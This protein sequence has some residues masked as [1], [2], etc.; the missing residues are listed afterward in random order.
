MKNFLSIAIFILSIIPFV[1][2]AQLAIKSHAEI[3][4]RSNTHMN[5]A[6]AVPQPLPSFDFLK[7][8]IEQALVYIANQPPGMSEPLTHSLLLQHGCAPVVKAPSGIERRKGGLN[9]IT[10]L[11]QCRDGYVQVYECNYTHPTIQEEWVIDDDYARDPQVHRYTVKAFRSEYDGKTRTALRW[12]NP[13]YQII[14]EIYPDRDDAAVIEAYR[15][16]IR[17]TAR[18]ILE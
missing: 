17:F 6:Q 15:D 14:L 16:I 8:S 12:I 13:D 18:A 9:G 3:P 11:Y 7:S 10:V 1:S 5:H 2:Q 4:E